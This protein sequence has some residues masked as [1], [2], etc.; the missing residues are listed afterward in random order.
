MITRMARAAYYAIQMIEH[1]NNDDDHWHVCLNLAKHYLNEID[2]D[3]L[4]PVEDEE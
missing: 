1:Y 4:K 2:L 3:I